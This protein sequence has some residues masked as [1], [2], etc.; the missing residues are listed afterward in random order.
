MRTWAGCALFLAL[1]LVLVTLPAPPAPAA[2]QTTITFWSH[3]HPP[4]VELYKKLIAEYERANPSGHVEYTIIPNNQFFAKVLTSMTT[5][6]G[7][8]VINMSSSQVFT[9]IDNNRVV[10]VDPAAFGVR[11]PQELEAV[12][13]QGA[14]AGA[15][16]RGKIYGIP[17]EYNVAVLV[18]NADHFKAAGLN[19]ADPIESWDDLVRIAQKLTVRQGDRITRRGFDFPYL[20]NFYSNT[21]QI[22]LYQAGGSILNPQQTESVINSPAGVRALTF[23]RDVIRKYHIGGPEYSPRDATNPMQDYTSGDVSMFIAYPWTLPAAESN[24]TVYGAT[25]VKLLPQF[26][27]RRPATIA[28]AYY[29]MVNSESKNQPEAWKFINFLSSR[30][31]RWLK[32]VGFVQPRKGWESTPEARNFPFLDVWLQAMEQ[33]RFILQHPRVPEIGQTIIRAIERTIFNNVDP[34]ASLDQAK[35]E[36]DEV[37]K[38]K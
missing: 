36:I 31:T 15:T 34:K 30:P 13:R 21:F 29:W 17:S 12:W 28:Y 19:P 16:R 22:L 4:M 38:Q 24:P 27:P 25:R 7:P 9:Y 37:L 11:S 18:A 1:V 14:L 35:R 10:P 5:G 20:Q 3:T 8:D 6:T 23:W 26:D 33:S 32:E 2:P